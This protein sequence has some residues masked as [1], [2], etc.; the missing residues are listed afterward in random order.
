MKKSYFLMAAAAALFA[1][2]AETDFVNEAVVVEE[3]PTLIGFETF[4]N[5]LTRA[6]DEELHDGGFRVWG[7]AAENTV[8]NG[9]NVTWNKP[10]SK[11]DCDV[12]R[13][14]SKSATYNFYASAPIAGG[15]TWDNT[16]QK[17]T[18]SGAQSGTDYL[19]ATK[20]G[21]TRENNTDASVEFTFNHVM[22]KVSLKLQ[23]G[24]NIDQ[25]LIVTSVEMTG[26]DDRD[27]SYDSKATPT[28]TQS[29]ADK[30]GTAAFVTTST[31]L[32]TTSP[33]AVANEFLIIPQKVESLQFTISYTLGGVAFNGYVATLPDQTWSE[34]QHTTYTL[35]IGPELITFGTQQVAGWAT[36]ATPGTSIGD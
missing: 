24:D 20:L 4:S 7:Y 22:S 19:T 35:T 32:I 15:A 17:F 16:N 12:K 14:W 31:G 6:G 21:V 25:D 26:W 5:K 3:T 34:N 2:C 1:A 10:E 8:F 28:W 13:Y 9:A 33:T 27:G 11:W 18:I 30:A 23:K 36:S 29:G